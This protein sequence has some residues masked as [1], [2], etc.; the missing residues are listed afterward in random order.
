MDEKSLKDRLKQLSLQE[1]AGQLN[2]LGG[3]IYSDFSPEKQNELLQRGEIGNMMYFDPITNNLQQKKQLSLNNHAIPILF[4]GD[5]IHGIRTIFP[6]PL[7]Q[8]ASFDPQMA[9]QTACYMAKEGSAL[10]GRWTFAPM[11]DIARDARW[12][13]N[14]E[15]AGEDPF[16]AAEMTMARVKGFQGHGISID[17]N[18][19]A[20]T[21]KH[22]A[23]YSYLEEGCEYERV[24]ASEY[25]LRTYAFPVYQSGI[26]AGASSVMSAF[27]DV[28]GRPCTA[29]EPLLKGVLRK[30]MGFSGVVVSDYAAIRQLVTSHYSENEKEAVYDAFEAGNDI[31]ME[32]RLYIRYL[33]ELVEEGRISKDELDQ[34]V[35]RVL[36]L[37][38]KVGLFEHPF[39]DETRKDR[40][41]LMPEALKQAEKEAIKDAVLLKNDGVLPLISNISLGAMGPLFDNAIDQNGPWSFDNSLAQSQ[42]YRL[43][44]AKAFSRLHE[45]EDD[46]VLYFA[47]LP[48]DLAGEAASLSDL[49]LPKEQREVIRSLANKGKKVILILTCARPMVLTEVA[50]LCAAILEMWAPGTMG[51]PALAKLLLGEEEPTGHLPISFPRA[52]S[53][54][55][56]YYNGFRSPRP[57]NPDDYYTSK[58]RDL[59]Y[60]PL[61]PFGYGLSY[62]PSALKNLSFEKDT[63]GLSETLKVSALIEN[64]S[65]K[66][67]RRLIQIYAHKEFAKPLRPDQSLVGFGWAELKPGE[68][69]AVDLLIP[70]V[71]LAKNAEGAG[72]YTLSLANNATDFIV[73]KTVTIS[74]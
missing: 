12:G 46:V 40:D 13:R 32:S 49:S 38:N 8:A 29:S 15:G 65:K 72:K 54:C 5:I 42:T 73:S 36:R 2:M 60:G 58:W 27:N 21:I 11:S 53:Q 35:M 56:I 50:P 68:K 9:E 71:R 55:P 14:I 7:A 47:G 4:C 33:P 63:Y 67:I 37:K 41:L 20:S 43:S 19:L 30:E 22:F 61:Y 59:E 74:K 3:S 45:G 64:L 24:I 51:G 10:G 26:Q 17:E 70:A 66:P 31:D 62:N 6:C 52:S 34:A 23:G 25:E 16:L 39:T 57:Y 48:R 44:L 69:K 28:S 18:H 1:K